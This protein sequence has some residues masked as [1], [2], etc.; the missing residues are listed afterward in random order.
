M[1]KRLPIRPALLVA[2]AVLLAAP[3]AAAKG[4]K[5][6]GHPAHDDHA[7]QAAMHEMAATIPMASTPMLNVDGKKLAISDVAGEHGTLVIFSCNACPWAQAWEERIVAIGNT[8]PEKGVG[9]IVI[10]PND[11]ERVAADGYSEMQERAGAKAYGFP[12]VVDETSDVARAF[13]ATRTPEVFLYDAEGHLV[14]HGAID[15]DAKQPEKVESHYLREAL[16]ALIAG[17]EI[18]LAETKAM[19]CS[20]KFRPEA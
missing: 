17:D 5:A 7:H 15:D 9:V 19:G 20:I 14:Y 18:P 11:P 1:R 2:G 8:Y 16:D 10:N 4:E 13:G 6:A 12:Y 3:M